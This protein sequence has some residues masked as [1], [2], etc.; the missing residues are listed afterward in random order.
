MSEDNIEAQAH[1]MGWAPKEEWRGPEE[2]WVDAKTFVERT[3]HIMP[4]LKRDRDRLKTELA[5]RDA[6][7]AQAEAAIKENLAS[8]EAF[9]EFS[10]ADTKRRV[11][12][13]RADLRKQLKAAKEAGDVDA[14]VEV[15]EAMAKLS[16][17]E[18]APAKKT[19]TK[20]PEQPIITPEFREWAS[21][22]TWFSVPALNQQGDPEKSTYAYAQAIW[23]EA[24]GLKGRELLDAITK[25]V[26]AKFPDT[27]PRRG[28]PSKVEGSR[29]G[30]SHNGSKHSFADLSKEDRE[31][32]ERYAEKVVGKNKVYATRAEFDKSYLRRVFPEDYE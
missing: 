27:N 12:A 3:E 8:M 21:E 24:K 15:Q 26:Q 6:R 10:E 1:E 5:A 31:A 4:M 16:A 7:L 9:K 30:A 13:A 11:E 25:E 23:L 22:N 29:T 18:S 20:P 28:A 2:K 14:E 32:V 17:Q 19:E